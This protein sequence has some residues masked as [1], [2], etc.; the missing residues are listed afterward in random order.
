MH[1]HM[2]E[3]L[4]KWIPIIAENIL[5]PPFLRLTVK[6]YYQL[7]IIHAIYIMQ[8]P[9]CDSVIHLSSE[10]LS[11]TLV[12]MVTLEVWTMSSVR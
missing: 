10:W 6:S 11:H 8:S 4:C 12:F 2:N 5:S 9:W 3:K 1:G 7:N